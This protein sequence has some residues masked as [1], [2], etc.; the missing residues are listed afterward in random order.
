VSLHPRPDVAIPDETRRVA[1]AAF[2]KG[3]TCLRIADERG[4][5]YRDD[6][7]AALFPSR[8]R[9]AASPA[10]RDASGEGEDVPDVVDLA[11]SKVIRRAPRGR[12]PS[13]RDVP[14][15]R[16]SALRV[17]SGPRRGPGGGFVVAAVPPAR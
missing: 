16:L 17:P 7:S 3:T 14:D 15:A 4:P 2:P 8:I 1:R 10:V 11:I 13:Q 6:Q 9:P 5:P 12:R